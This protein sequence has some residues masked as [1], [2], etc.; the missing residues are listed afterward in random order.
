M[1]DIIFGNK[2]SLKKKKNNTA[3]LNCLCFDGEKK[4]CRI[5]LIPIND[6]NTKHI[7]AV[8]SQVCSFSAVGNLGEVGA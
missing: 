5:N 7:P 2:S 1:G 8:H 3:L 4:L 6:E